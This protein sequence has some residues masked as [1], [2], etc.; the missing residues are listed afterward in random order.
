METY[1]TIPT[2]IVNT[3]IYAFDKLDGSNIRAEWNHKSGFMKFGSRRRLLDPAEK[4]LGDAIE[5]FM[6]KYADDLGAIFKKERMMRATAFFEFHSPNS[7]AGQHVDEPHDVTLFDLHVY[8][9]GMLP[10]KQ[11]LRLFEDKVDIAQVLYEGKPN[12][13]LVDAV[14]SS[15]LEGMTFEGVVCKGDLDNRRRPVT[16]KLKSEAW[17]VALR[18]K[19]GHD[20][21]LMKKLM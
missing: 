6:N 12:Q 13:H 4:P 14:R 3:P 5:L 16:F 1:P 2:N 11:F 9:Q 19:Y 21:D 7:F 17:F 15:Q 10:P 8:K 18:K 20:E